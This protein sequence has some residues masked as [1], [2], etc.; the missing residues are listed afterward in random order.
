MGKTFSSFSSHA[1]FKASI[2]NVCPARH[3]AFSSVVTPSTYCSISFARQAPDASSRT[4]PPLYGAK[5]SL[6][7]SAWSNVK[8]IW[9]PKHILQTAAAAPPSRK[10]EADSTCFSSSSAYTALYMAFS[11]SQFGIPVSLSSGAGT[12]KTRDP[13]F[14][15]A[16]EMVLDAFVM[17]TAKLTSV[18][19]TSKSSN[20]PDI[21][22]LP[23]IEG[24]PSA[25]C[26]C[27]APKSAAA[28]FPQRSGLSYKRSKYSWKV[29][30]A[31]SGCAPTASSLESDST[32]A[33]AAPWNGL[34]RA[35]PGI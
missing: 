20:E 35:I 22:S 9:L 8:P 2:S 5:S 21:L 27:M 19:G 11:F 30:L 13:A 23:P 34:Q 6:S 29:S 14:L 10:T 32:T 7:V 17:A 28:G 33:Q 24:M 18:G 25:S 1:L 16:A 31:E 4:S 12:Y 26:A 3:T 15:N